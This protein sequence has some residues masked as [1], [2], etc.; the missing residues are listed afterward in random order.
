LPINSVA[1]DGGAGDVEKNQDDTQ[2]VGVKKASLDKPDTQTDTQCVGGGKWKIGFCLHC[3]QE[4]EKKTVW[5]KFCSEFCRMANYEQRTGKK[6]KIKKV[7]SK[8]S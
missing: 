5:Q 6:L 4:F 2:C 8:L 3:A 7:T 1:K